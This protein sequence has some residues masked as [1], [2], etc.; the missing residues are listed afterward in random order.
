MAA[1]AAV[2]AGPTLAA[3]AATTGGIEEGRA[4]DR[5]DVVDH[6]G[7]GDGRGDQRGHRRSQKHTGDRTEADRMPTICSRVA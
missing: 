5:T 6:A 3:V 1:V 2:A 4:A 7:V